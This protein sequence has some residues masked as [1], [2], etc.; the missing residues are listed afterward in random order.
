VGDLFVLIMLA[1]GKSDTDGENKVGTV[2]GL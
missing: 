2:G 1:C